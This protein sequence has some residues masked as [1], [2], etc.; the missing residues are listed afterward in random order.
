MSETTIDG[1]P[2]RLVALDAVRGIAAACVVI[3]HITAT[4]VAV[5]APG[6]PTSWPRWLTVLTPVHLLWDGPIAVTVFFVLSGFVL[7]LP[8]LRRPPWD[9]AANVRWLGFYP[10]RLV[11]LYLPAWGALAIAFGIMWVVA[12]HPT[13]SG[14]AWLAHHSHHP[15]LHALAKGSLLLFGAGSIDGPL[16]SLGLEVAYSMLLPAFI[17]V[18]VLRTVPEWAKWLAFVAL[19]AMAGA[20]GSRSASLLGAFGLGALLASAHLRRPVLPRAFGAPAFVAIALA[21]LVGLN[22]G[23]VVSLAHLPHHLS[24]GITRALTILGATGV[25]FVVVFWQS[26]ARAL[27]VAPLEW[28]GT[29]SF[30]L[31]LIHF[32]VVIAL[33]HVIDPDHLVV[34]IAVELAA[35]LLAAEAF[36]R[37]IERPSHR[38]SKRVGA[39]VEAKGRARASSAE[40]GV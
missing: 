36:C 17:L 30:S 5:A 25:V 7:S 6:T 40:A 2:N 29:R 31:Y 11:R 16:W 37:L 27:S 14:S 1:T 13:T 26:A 15:T 38:L 12:R 22:A 9:A 34:L 8:F 4:N 20:A 18:C 28:L 33:S 24:G 23:P 21:S 32:P 10:K 35:S 39:L 19:V 3:A